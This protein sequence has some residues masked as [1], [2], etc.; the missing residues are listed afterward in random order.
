[1]AT[2]KY[3]RLLIGLLVLA[4]A[5]SARAQATG[6]DKLEGILAR[7]PVP[8]K[9]DGKLAEVDKKA[10]DAAVAELLKSP[11][12]AA[13]GL[14]GRLTTKGDDIQ[15]RHAIHAVVMRVGGEK[16][17]AL[18]QA[19]ARGLA[20]TLGTDR[21][22]EVQAFVLRQ[23][24]LVGGPKEAAVVGKMLQ[25]PELAEPSA[26]ALLAIRTGAAEQFR[27]ALTKATGRQRLTIVHGLGTLKDGEAAPALRKLLEEKDAD[28]RLTAAW[29]LANAADAEAAEPLLRMAEG[30][31]G[32]ERSRATAHCFLLGENLLA[33]KNQKAARAIY[34]HLRKTRTASGERYIQEAAARALKGIE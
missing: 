33:A 6:E 2:R 9:K 13:A 5:S 3:G 34:E 15:A 21:P 7:F 14:V 1:M 17:P 16:D 25:D 26:Q 10:T 20:G 22:R 24:Q 4:A 27:A 29:A 19:V 18:R 28:L 31:K 8:A 11:E 23:L 32:F 12:A 30:A